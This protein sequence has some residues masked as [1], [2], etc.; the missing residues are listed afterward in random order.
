MVTLPFSSVLFALLSSFLPFCSGITDCN[1]AYQ[2]Q[3]TTQAET[4]GR[5]FCRGFRSCDDAILS[6]SDGDIICSGSLSCYE[7]Q[8]ITNAGNS[9][10]ACYGAMS[11]SE[12]EIFH[13]STSHLA[14]DRNDFVCF[15]EKSC[16]NSIMHLIDGSKLECE[17]ARSCENS[18]IFSE[19][20]NEFTLTG[21]LS[22]HNTT[23]WTSTDTTGTT[24]IS[25]S[26]VSSCHN[27]I[28]KCAVGSTCS[29]V[30]S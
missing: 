15:G 27:M 24:T 1:D 26:A 6:N 30:V 13:D 10:T 9:S 22:G 16:A 18:E 7:A 21:F 17:G 28:V 4:S 20:T 3:S 11:C 5:L 12:T 25:C 2:C 14:A 8:S 29:V 23:I 19:G